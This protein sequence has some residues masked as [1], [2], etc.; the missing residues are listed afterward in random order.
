MKTA[1]VTAPTGEP[2]SVQEVKDH[3]RITH[4]DDPGYLG[5]LITTARSYVE[6]HCNRALITQTWDVFLD[7]FPTCYGYVRGDYF[8]GM[9][10]RVPLPPLQSVTTLKYTDNDGVQQTWS[11]S[12]YTVDIKGIIARI[13]P[14][15][16]V[17]WPI[18]RVVP[19]AVEIRVVVGYGNASTVPQEI[20][21]AMLLLISHWYENREAVTETPKSVPW[22]MSLA[23]AT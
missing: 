2:L 23:F 15:Y 11:S 5:A 17:S 10:I 21:Q 22:M 12:N 1:L 6:N 9:E 19:N 7:K 3:L 16:G 4:N 13:V 14:A 20:K 8:A 18:T